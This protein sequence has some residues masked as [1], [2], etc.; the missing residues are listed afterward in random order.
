VRAFAKQYDWKLTGDLRPFEACIQ[1][2]ARAKAVAKITTTRA[3]TNG[4]CLFMDIYGP[5]VASARNNKY[6]VAVVDDDSR[7]EGSRFIPNKSDIVE[8][9]RM[10]LLKNQ[11]RCDNAGE[12][13]K[14]LETL[15][16]EAE[17]TFILEHTAPSTPQMNGVVE[18]ACI[19]IRDRGFSMLLDAKLTSNARKLFWSNAMDTATILDN[20][21]P[22]K[23]STKTP[24]RCGENGR[25]S[26]GMISK[27]G[28]ASPTL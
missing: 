25:L 5:Y 11:I 18:R 21:L 16:L 6:W 14:H 1:A 28:D 15:G 2:K 19:T 8:V 13:V 26:I 20:P 3:D 12:N 9:L 7:R 27:N 24:T 17:T 10:I 22:R 4:E 23:D